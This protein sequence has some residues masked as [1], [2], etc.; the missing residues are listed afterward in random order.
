MQYFR[1]FFI[2]TCLSLALMTRAHG[3]DLNNAY[4]EEAENNGANEMQYGPI[5]DDGVCYEPSRWWI[6]FGLGAG[7]TFSSSAQGGLGVHYS[8]NGTFTPHIVLTFYRNVIAL[9]SSVDDAIQDFGVM[10]GYVDRKPRGFWS[11]ST[12][13]AYYRKDE[14]YYYNY[15]SGSFTYTKSDFQTTASGAALPVQVQAFWTPFRH[16]GV[17]L[18]GH[19]V[20][21]PH[22]HASL[23]LAI[24]IS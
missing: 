15:S 1:K 21:V 2:L 8:F 19:G 20:V 24:Q 10:L 7:S 5:V 18:I 13:I 6:N 14:K 3:N 12:G 23:L 11:L 17:G 16:F 9:N 22:P 4:S